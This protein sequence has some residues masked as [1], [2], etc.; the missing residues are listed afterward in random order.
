MSSY[1]HYALIQIGHVV[2][3][4]GKTPAE[5]RND[6]RHVLETPDKADETVPLNSAV[7]GDLAIVHCT[8]ELAARVRSGGGDILYEHDGIDY[9]RLPEKPWLYR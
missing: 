4:V 9:I 6:A 2:L 8:G 7:A 5:A 1:T 3:G